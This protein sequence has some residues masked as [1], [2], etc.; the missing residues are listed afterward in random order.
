[1]S[2]Y[3]PLTIE[4]PDVLVL[5]ILDKVIFIISTSFH[6]CV[7]I[8]ISLIA[9]EFEYVKYIFNISFTYLFILGSTGV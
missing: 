1:M 3:T 9:N 4:D 2:V 5:L 7:S 8:Y 6:P